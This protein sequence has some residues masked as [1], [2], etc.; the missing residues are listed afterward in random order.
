M[1]GIFFVPSAFWL[2][3]SRTTVVDPEGDAQDVHRFS[4]R[5]GCLIEKSRLR[6]RRQFRIGREVFSLVIFFSKRK[7]LAHQREKGAR[8]YPQTNAIRNPKPFDQNE[9]ATDRTPVK[10]PVRQD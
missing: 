9:V 7:P 10:M 3:D 8:L 6:L 2:S 5:Q 1:H 4:M